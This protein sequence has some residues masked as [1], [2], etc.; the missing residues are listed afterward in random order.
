MWSREGREHRIDVVGVCFEPPTFVCSVPALTEKRDPSHVCIITTRQAL[1]DAPHSRLE[2]SYNK[3]IYGE[4][5][6]LHLRGGIMSER[7]TADG[8]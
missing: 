7:V 8:K 5:S 3:I 6:S 1:D 2:K 4:D